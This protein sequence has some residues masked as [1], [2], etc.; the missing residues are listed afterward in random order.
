MEDKKQPQL[1]KGKVA[2]ISQNW[3]KIQKKIKATA[4]P[5]PKRREKLPDTRPI[6]EQVFDP[7]PA[8]F[9]G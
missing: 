7:R 6:V 8:A 9:T 4:P 3:K 2:N 5:G 1:G